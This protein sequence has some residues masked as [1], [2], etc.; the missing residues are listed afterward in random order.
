MQKT[1]S[2]ILFLLILVLSL[3]TGCTTGVIPEPDEPDPEPDPIIPNRVVMIELFVAPGCPRCPEA[4]T[5]M[6]QL[7]GEYGLDKIVVLEEYA[8]NYPLSFS[9]GWATPETVSRYSMYTSN[10]STPD[11]YFN[12]LNQAVHHD[13]SSYYNYKNAIDEELEKPVQISISASAV[14]NSS[15]KSINITGNIQNIGNNTFSNIIIGTMIYENSVSLIVPG[16]PTY[17]VN[18]VVRDILTPVQVS[19]LSSEATYDFSFIANSE[20]LKYVDNFNNLHI[21]VYVQAPNSST[22]EILQALYVE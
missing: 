22:K 11:A 4:K 12:G 16:K 21:V 3:C 17:T 15:V 2:A 5:Y 14:K 18:H 6:A 1:L 20:D 13:D 8:W 19:S 7:L 9:S 10:T